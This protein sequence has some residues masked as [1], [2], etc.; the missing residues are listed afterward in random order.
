MII[1]YDFDGTLTPYSLPQYDILK[2]CGYDDNRLMDIIEETMKN[3]NTSL[4]EAYFETYKE[5]LKNN[6]IQFNRNN[7][8]IGASC[9]KL[10][11]GVVN[12][13]NNLQYKN[14]GI[15]HYVVTAGFEEYIKFTPISEFLDGIY[16]TS[17]NLEDETYT[18]INTLVTD[19]YKVDIIKNIQ[20]QN[21]VD[22][23]DI[24]YMGDGLTD[25][26]AF[27]FVHNN[28]GKAIFISLGAE[29]SE[30]YKQLEKLGIIDKCF[31]PDFSNNSGIYSY[32]KE[33]I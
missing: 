27:E 31:E 13:F 15:K 3:K 33:I 24:I 10:N 21:N 30:K 8:C 18:G 9:V 26:M 6:N 25:K 11:N 5:V 2:K 12:Y 14:T 17:F 1:I 32:I 28:G 7:V 22:M 19:E 16:G 20:K 29:Q 4:Y 23:Q